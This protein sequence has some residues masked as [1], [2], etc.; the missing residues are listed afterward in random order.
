MRSVNMEHLRPGEIVAERN[1]CS[2]VYL[3]VGPLEWHGPA[4]P[5]GT[6]PLAAAE[7][8]KRAAQITGGVV[9]PTVYCGT[10]RERTAEMLEAFGFQDTDQYI[11]GQDFPANSMKSF[12]TKEDTFSLIIRE[13][14]RLLAEQEYEMIVIVNGHGAENQKYQLDRLACEFSN[15]TNTKVIVAMGLAPLDE[16]D[17]DFGH[18]T[19]METSIQMYLEPENVK[20]SCLPPKPAKLNNWE[21]GIDDASTFA[22][23]PNLD[24]TVIYDPRDATETLGKRYV[25]VGVNHLVEQVREAWKKYFPNKPCI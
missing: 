1:R 4:M 7:A 13:Y 17:L 20:L 25:E 19:R 2:L 15:E 14:L 21:W 24:K 16:N 22:L 6:D 11:C 23:K 18:A 3:P 8:A 12:Y 10:E 9:M 5:Y